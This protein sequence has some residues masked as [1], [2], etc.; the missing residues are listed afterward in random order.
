MIACLNGV[1]SS[2]ELKVVCSKKFD[3]ED[4]SVRELD[5]LR[6]RSS[7]FAFCVVILFV[8]HRRCPSVSDKET[9][10]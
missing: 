8:P 1:L 5:S 10:F 6:L 9:I 3:R 2:S 7:H 4:D